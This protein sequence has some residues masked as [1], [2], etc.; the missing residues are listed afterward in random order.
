MSQC[1]TDGL[2]NPAISFQWGAGIFYHGFIAEVGMLISKEIGL[3]SLYSG[4]NIKIIS[5][6]DDINPISPNIFGGIKWSPS[7]TNKLTSIFLEVYQDHNSDYFIGYGSSKS[8][9]IGIGFRSKIG[10]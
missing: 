9:Y 7:R 6:V 2:T 3:F 5:V 1:L 4:I 10:T 8:I